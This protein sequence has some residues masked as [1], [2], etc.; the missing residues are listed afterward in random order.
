M[1]VKKVLG[2][3][4]R[5]LKRVLLGSAAPA[6]AAP[7][8]AAPSHPVELDAEYRKVLEFVLEN[9]LSMCGYNNLVTT[10]LACKHVVEQGIEGAFVEC[11][12]W[13]GGH[14]I[15]AASVFERAKTLRKIYL[16]DTFAGMAEPSHQDQRSNDGTSAH[17]TYLA[18]KKETHTD[19]CYASLDEVKANFEKARLGKSN[20]VFVEGPVEQTLKTKALLNELEAQ[21]I[22]VLRLD[23]DWYES[24]KL[25]MDL[26]W[27]LVSR[28]GI[29][30]ADD[31]GY[32]TGAK[33]A[34]DESFG[35]C[36][37][38]FSFID[39]WARVAVKP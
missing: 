38:F 2:V 1:L 20:V 16:F 8:P 36:R 24:T 39:Y 30:V 10:L 19:W 12:V 11:G 27:P 17:A 29:F 22:S 6:P 35:P 13:R 4:K 15:L 32:W 23:T 28:S 21:R 5:R 3:V 9:K 14:A 37:P 34:V 33:K 26:L 18:K 31:Y 25:E 7:A